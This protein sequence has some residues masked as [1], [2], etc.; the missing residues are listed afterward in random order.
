[1]ATTK[2]GAKAPTKKQLREQ[3]KQ[4]LAEREQRLVDKY[5]SKSFQKVIPGSIKRGTGSYEGKLVIKINTVGIDGKPDGNTRL[6]ATSDVHEVQH[7]KEV[8]ELLRRQR[9]NERARVKRAQAS[10]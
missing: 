4:L 2:T 9:R 10:A 5:N 7:T 3:E 1:M 8:V 6:V